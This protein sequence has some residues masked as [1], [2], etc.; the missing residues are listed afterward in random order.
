MTKGLL[1][2]Y[3]QLKSSNISIVTANTLRATSG[4]E[5]D[6]YNEE[7]NENSFKLEIE[8]EMDLNSI[9]S[10]SIEIEIEIKKME[11]L[12]EQIKL[13]EKALAADIQNRGVIDYSIMN[14]NQLSKEE[15]LPP[16][17]LSGLESAMDSIKDGFKY[18]IENK[19]EILMKAW[20][21]IKEMYEWLIKKLE[22][23]WKKTKLAINQFRNY[24]KAIYEKF[25]VF[26]IDTKVDVSKLSESTKKEILEAFAM[27]AI[28]NTN[29]IFSMGKVTD[30]EL[31]R[32]VLSEN[33][34]INTEHLIDTGLLEKRNVRVLNY[35]NNPDIL[36]KNFYTANGTSPKG[37]KHDFK[38][39]MV[40]NFVGTKLIMLFID[41][42]INL[43][44]QSFTDFSKPEDSFFLSVDSA[45]I[46]N[47][48]IKDLTVDLG[49]YGD[50]VAITKLLEQFL[51]EDAEKAIDRQIKD[52]GTLDKKLKDLNNNL[53]SS[54]G[55]KADAIDAEVTKYKTIYTLLKTIVEINISTCLDCN[56]K[57]TKTMGLIAKESDLA[58]VQKK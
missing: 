30:L 9:K 31:V 21:K 48:V 14:Y 53:F 47:D 32:E 11:K 8:L 50:L 35:L 7:D 1:T 29:K 3:E 22:N 40:L 37:F 25:S 42:N 26:P 4:L 18:V 39:S 41:K 36:N 15:K 38:N 24:P 49:T 13:D 20:E 23:F 56:T 33:I 43:E 57:I 46:R 12:T 16:L 10:D 58:G 45:Y 17:E 5:S 51:K 19:K 55:I 2:D 34:F 54:S 44:T 52:L 6:V 28:S 27:F